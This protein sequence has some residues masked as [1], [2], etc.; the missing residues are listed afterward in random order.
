M[1]TFRAGYVSKVKSGAT[2]LF[3]NSVRVNETA[4]VGDVTHTGSQGCQVLVPGIK[5]RTYTIGGGFDFDAN[6]P[7]APPNIRIGETVSAF[8]AL[9]DGT[10]DWLSDAV[11]VS[12]EW[13]GGPSNQAVMFTAEL[14]STGPLT[15]PTT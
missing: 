15:W 8:H 10:E 13:L 14:R 11:V 4:E 9:P 5:R 12:F 3:V 2:E 6:Y 7:L 1:A